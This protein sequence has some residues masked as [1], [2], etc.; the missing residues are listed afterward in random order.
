MKRRYQGTP[1]LSVAALCR[2]FGYSRKV[3]VRVLKEQGVRI[4][5]HT[6]RNKLLVQ[7]ALTLTAA[8]WS[9]E[10]IARHLG[11]SAGTV[12]YWRRAAGISVGTGPGGCPQEVKQRVIRLAV[13]RGW[14]TSKIAAEVGCSET[15]VRRWVRNSGKEKQ[16]PKPGPKRSD[17][18]FQK[19]ID[20]SASASVREIVREVGL[21][22]QTVRRWLREAGLTASPAPPGSRQPDDLASLAVELY[23]DGL[24]TRKVAEKIGQP[25]SNVRYWISNAG[26][27]RQ[28]AASRRPDPLIQHAVE[29]YERGLSVRKTAEKIGRPWSTVRLWLSNAGVLRQPWRDTPAAPQYSAPPIATDSRQPTEE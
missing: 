11:V 22:E 6:E 2:E 16:T 1:T 19:V 29:L 21:S 27:M 13:D 9:C 26:V 7:Q 23:K 5:E 17:L 28:R 24:S 4:R 12:S 10:K 20:L 8:G 18:L 15:S 14:S 3:V 25:H